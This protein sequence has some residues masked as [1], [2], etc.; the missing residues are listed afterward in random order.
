MGISWLH[1]DISLLSSQSYLCELNNAW[2]S[3][4]PSAE[5]AILFGWMNNCP[6]SR[7]SSSSC[8]WSVG[9][10]RLVPVVVA[11]QMRSCRS[12]ATLTQQRVQDPPLTSAFSRVR[13][14]L[15]PDPPGLESL[16]TC[17]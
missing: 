10:F 12:G 1:K 2:H 16:F 11:S 13:I 4:A 14:A 17:F 7:G 8:R 15:A 3:V 5:R 6:N 9:V